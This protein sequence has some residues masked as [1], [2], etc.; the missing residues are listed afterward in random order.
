MH[1]VAALVIP[2]IGLR[3]VVDWKEIRR[4]LLFIELAIV[5][6]VL[7][8][9]AVAAFNYEFPSVAGGMIGLLT[10]IFL[11]RRGIGLAKDE[12]NDAGSV[13]RSSQS[14]SPQSEAST[15]H[16]GDIFRVLAPLL[17]TV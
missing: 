1:A 15:L 7:P 8:M 11:A 5:A 6:S 17:A 9:A 13:A 12:A 14:I 10:T 4:N 16:R 3:F 2:V